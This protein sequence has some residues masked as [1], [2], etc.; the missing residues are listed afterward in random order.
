VTTTA[1][2]KLGLETIPRN[3]I[4]TRVAE[5]LQAHILNQLKPGDMLPSE[6]ELV[7]RF[8]V[9]RSS[10]RDAIRSLESWPDIPP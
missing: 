9:S 2:S 1:P 7:R 6:R 4:F 5:Q 3:R 8:G 10:I